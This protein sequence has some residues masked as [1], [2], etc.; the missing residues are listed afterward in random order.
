M[1]S[2]LLFSSPMMKSGHTLPKV[3]S[4]VIALILLT[5]IADDDASARSRR[6]TRRRYSSHSYAGH[7]FC[8]GGNTVSGT[9]YNTPHLDDRRSWSSYRSW[10]QAVKVEGSGIL[11]DGRVQDYTGHI[12]AKANCAQYYG[13][14][15][16]KG[17]AGKCLVPFMSIA[18]D[19]SIYPM[20]TIIDIP[21]LHGVTVRAPPSEH[22]DTIP[23]LFKCA[24]TGGKIKGVGRFDFYTGS[25]GDHDHR[26]DFAVGQYSMGPGHCAMKFKVI[27]QGS[28]EYAE[29][30]ARW[31]QYQNI[32]INGDTRLTKATQQEKDDASP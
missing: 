22:P 3:S 23:G 26:N 12:R 9:T 11:P 13:D 18:C 15:T 29:A 5:I 7:S 6:H 1:A 21:N 20:G 8:G 32:A 28:S 25:Y 16:V 31:E 19:R 4:V 17:A 10:G 30:D 27:R 14:Y 2:R 24:D